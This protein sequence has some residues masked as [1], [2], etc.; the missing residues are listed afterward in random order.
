MTTLAFRVISDE[1]SPRFLGL[2]ASERNVRVVEKLGRLFAAEDARHE[3]IP[4]LHIGAAAAWFVAQTTH[5]TMIAGALLFWCASIADG[6]DGEMAR[7]TLSESALGEHLDTSVD[8]ATHL[9]AFGGVIVGWWRQGISRAGWALAI[10]V[11][12]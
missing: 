9:L 11:A 6:I 8:H 10:A 5:K 7:L 3:T 12:I 2:H 4:A 1:P